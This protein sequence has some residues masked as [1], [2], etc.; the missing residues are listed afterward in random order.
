MET[1][2]EIPDTSLRRMKYLQLV[3]Y[4]QRLIETDQLHINDR[5]P[6]LKQLEQQFSMSKET[7]LKGL[8]YLLEKGIIE[9]V[10]RKGYYVKKKSVE[11]SYRVFLLLDKMNIL[12]DKFY[13]TL[14][15]TIKDKADIDIYFHHHNNK[16]FEKLIAE[17][18]NS[19][20]HFVIATF[21]KE[22]VSP[23]LNNIPP[24]KRIIID[25]DQPGL[26][27][28]YTSIY[29]DFQSDIYHGL[30]QLEP[31][32][33]KYKKLILIVPPEAFHAKLVI[34]G[35]LHF[36]HE[37]TYKYVI[38]HEISADNFKKGNVY[39]TFSRYDTDD[40]ALIKLAREKQFT[41]GKDIGLISYNDTS[42]KEILEGGI[43]VIS[44]DFEAMAR[45]VAA[46]IETKTPVRERNPTHVIL[47]NSV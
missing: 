26:E 4:I 14:F 31:Q 19:Y 43:T 28:D 27:G 38:Q 2:A 11:H 29:Q 15:D 10:Y 9:S 30:T 16:V 45:K 6:S 5:L 3:D 36:C 12:R 34:D 13:H 35:F 17:N 23:V 32:L 40:V 44:S 24:N 18:L 21:L 1:Q 8:N 20:T 41:L 7:V 37:H 42:V 47:R 22:D 46:V 25:F 33:Q 39:I